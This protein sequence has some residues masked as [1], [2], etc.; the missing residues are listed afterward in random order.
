MQ[1]GHP[2]PVLLQASGSLW[3]LGDGGLPIGVL[4]SPTYEETHF[5]FGPEDRLVVYS[6]GLTDT[7]NDEGADSSEER[8]LGLL[9]DDA[10][11]PTSQLM[12]D[13][14]RKLRAWQGS[15]KLQ[16]DVTVLILEAMPN[17]EDDSRTAGEC[18]DLHLAEQRLDASSAPAFRTDLLHLIE[19]GNC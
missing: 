7:R 3:T 16:D 5:V 2:C 1:A 11:L 15:T 6:D 4:P 8:L 14:V 18:V 19:A 12:E 13:L 9:R 17:H 10:D